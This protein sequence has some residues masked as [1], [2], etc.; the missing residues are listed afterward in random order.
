LAEVSPTMR[1]FSGSA[2]SASSS[3]AER[4]RKEGTV[5]SSTRFNC[6]GTP[7]LRKYFCASTSEATCDQASGTSTFSALNTVEPSGLRISDVVK[8][9]WISA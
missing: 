9:N 2:A 7:A 8:R 4:H 6:A 5:S 1:S 3:G